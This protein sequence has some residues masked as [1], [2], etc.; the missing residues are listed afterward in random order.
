MRDTPYDL[1][2]RTGR[3]SRI[4]FSTF[5]VGPDACSDHLNG[6]RTKAIF[7]KLKLKTDRNRILVNYHS[8]KESDNAKNFQIPLTFS[9]SLNSV[10]WRISPGPS[11]RRTAGS[12][13]YRG[14]IDRQPCKGPKFCRSQLR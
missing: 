6:Q 7:K 14:Y 9:Y 4:R 3:N 5:A 2:W 10:R 12:G 8:S 13:L 1:S 11:G